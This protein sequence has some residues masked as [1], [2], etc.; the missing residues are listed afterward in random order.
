[1]RVFV[2]GI[3]RSFIAATCLSAAL[4]SPASGQVSSAAITGVVRDQAGAAVPGATV[5]VT[6]TE[7]N[8]QRIVATTSDGVY[9]APGLLPGAYRVG[10]GLNG[11]KPLRR[12]G[13]QAATG[14]TIRLDLELSVGD[15]REQV[16]VKGD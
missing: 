2:V 14:Q 13:I 4:A 11:F 1:M 12:E 10:V 5:T 3:P 6:N 15:V 7:T 16:R 9:T 8:R